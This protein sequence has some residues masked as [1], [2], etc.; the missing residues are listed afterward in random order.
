[1]ASSK[2]RYSSACFTCDIPFNHSLKT[3]EVLYL[4]KA[5]PG[6]PLRAVVAGQLAAGPLGVDGPGPLAADLADHHQNQ[7]FLLGGRAEAAPRGPLDMPDLMP[8]GGLTPKNWNR[9]RNIW[10]R[11]LLASR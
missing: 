5:V 2:S 8:L 1:M 3:L 4:A 7:P 9:A 11:A 10:P 6:L